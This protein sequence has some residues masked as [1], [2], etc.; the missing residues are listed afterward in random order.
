MHTHQNDDLKLIANNWDVLQPAAEHGFEQHGRGM[1]FID[2]TRF[3]ND[4]YP[5]QYV[6]LAAIPN[7]GAD[8]RRMVL[9]YDPQKEIVLSLLGTDGLMHS[10]QVGRSNTTALNLGGAARE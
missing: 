4:G 5:I 8:C 6:T 9:S 2:V 1:V 3:V 7:D 10:Y